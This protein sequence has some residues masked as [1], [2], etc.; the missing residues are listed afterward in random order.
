MLACVDVDYRDPEAF[1][2]C[3]LFRAWPDERPAGEHVERIARVEPYQPGQFYKRELPCL[4][5]VLR[6]RGANG[7]GREALEVVVVDGY[8]WLRDETSPGLGGHLY[9]ALGRAVPVIGVTKTRFASARA[10]RAVLRG[11]SRRP[12]YVTA[13]GLDVE[14]AARC[15]QRMHGAHRVPTLL[16]RVDL[17]CRG[18]GRGAS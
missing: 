7:A 8:V 3:V 2:A 9:E 1:A 13:A 15:V 11:D 17:L 4:L 12:L 10:A 16:K 14:E 5:A 6:G 18:A